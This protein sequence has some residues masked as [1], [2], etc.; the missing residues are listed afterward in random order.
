MNNRYL[1]FKQTNHST[2][3]RYLVQTTIKVSKPYRKTL[4]P[5]TGKREQILKPAPQHSFNCVVHEHSPQRV[6]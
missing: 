1:F 2:R 4:N 5:E 6:I 3:E